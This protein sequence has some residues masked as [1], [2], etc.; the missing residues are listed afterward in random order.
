[1]IPG[2]ETR[3]KVYLFR[4]IDREFT[5]LAYQPQENSFSL[6]NIKLLIEEYP[7]KD[8]ILL[9]ILGKACYHNE[10]ELVKYLLTYNINLNP[11]LNKV[12][13]KGS[14]T[15]DSVWLYAVP[16]TWAVILENLE[17]IKLLLAHGANA[18]LLKQRTIETLLERKTGKE[19]LKLLVK[20]GADISFLIL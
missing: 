3:D 10:I 8:E 19:T 11:D 7:E 20:Y 4:A 2:I 14:P 16:L 17:I 13:I 12:R 6:N 9:D 15:Y 5:N 18:S 1:M